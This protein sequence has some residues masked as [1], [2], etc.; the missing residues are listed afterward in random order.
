VQ[1]AQRSEQCDCQAV[2][3]QAGAHNA[4]QDSW[5]G[6]QLKGGLL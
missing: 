5:Q 2:L 4:Q 1:A 6:Q 3:Q